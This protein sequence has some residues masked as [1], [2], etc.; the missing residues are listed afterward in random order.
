MLSRRAALD[1]L[2][3]ASVDADELGGASRLVGLE[4]AATCQV[5]GAVVVAKEAEDGIVIASMEDDAQVEA[6]AGR[7]HAAV[8]TLDAEKLESGVVPSYRQ[9]ERRT[10][11]WPQTPARRP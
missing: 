7:S 2:L 6:D 10:P 1:D 5:A 3:G 9:V 4:S 11:R 8:A